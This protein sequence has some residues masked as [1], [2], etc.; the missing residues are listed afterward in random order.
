VIS[1]RDQF[2]EIP[3]AVRFFKLADGIAVSSYVRNHR[4]AKDAQEG[5]KS[6]PTQARR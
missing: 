6:A 1:L 2:Q 4:D 5:R 3:L